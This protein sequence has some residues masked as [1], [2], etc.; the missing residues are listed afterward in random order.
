MN[1][2][3]AHQLPQKFSMDQLLATLSVMYPKQFLHGMN[4]VELRA[5]RNI[6]ESTLARFLASPSMIDK[7]LMLLPERH[8]SYPPTVGEFLAVLNEINIPDPGKQ[9]SM[10]YLCGNCGSHRLSQ[11]HADRCITE[12]SK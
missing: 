1:N 3:D 8:P 11:I 5:S 7:A 10:D 12:Q 9:I 2:Q 4:Q 6:W